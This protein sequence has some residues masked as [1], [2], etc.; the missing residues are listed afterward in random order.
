MSEIDELID[1][2]DAFRDARDWRQFHNAK[3]LALSLSLEASELLE[4]FQWK[5]ADD[6]VRERRDALAEE[7]ADV[8]IYAL[9]MASD[10]DLNPADIVREKLALNEE[11]YPVAASYGRSDKYVALPRTGQ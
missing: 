6:A 11:K 4:V 8:L 5:S 2:I 1:Q 10:L 3:D 7:L 9:M